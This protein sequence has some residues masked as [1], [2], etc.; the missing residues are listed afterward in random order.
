MKMLVAGGV[1]AVVLSV[2]VSGQAPAVA[3]AGKAPSFEVASVRPSNPNPSDP[4]GRMPRLM[5]VGGRLTVANLPLR[6]LIRVAYDVQDFQIVGG[7][8]ELLSRKFDITAKAEDGTGRT[9]KEMSVL[10]RALLADRFALAVRTE[11]REAP[12][13]ALVVVRKDGA[14]GPAMKVSASDCGGLEEQTQKRLETLA[15]DGPGAIMKALAAGPI[16][17]TIMPAGVPGTAGAGFGMRGNGQ[18]MEG[19]VRLL[20][21]AVDRSVVDDTGLTGLYDWELHFDPEVFLRAAGQ[22]GLNLPPFPPAPSDS[23]SLMTA[24]QEQLGLKLEARRGPV[25][26]LVIEHVEAPAPD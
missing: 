25:D 6:V 14:L 20:T 26:H 13:Y 9:L 18:P 1:L 22:A 11:A 23:P 7:P 5:P 16:P 2:V 17:C 15:K 24:I 19:L 3:P 8:A 21:Q 12:I 4:M 10:L